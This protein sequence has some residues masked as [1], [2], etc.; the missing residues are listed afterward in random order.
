[1][2]QLIVDNQERGLL[3]WEETNIGE[4]AMYECPCNQ[5]SFGR[6]ASRLCTGNF[7][8]GGYWMESDTSPCE[9]DPLAWQLCDNNVRKA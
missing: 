7:T 6:R 4:I 1:M 2:E 9:F 3:L 5:T 8:T